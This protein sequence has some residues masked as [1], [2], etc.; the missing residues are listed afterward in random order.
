MIA[1][2]LVNYM[3]P[4]LRPT[5]EIERAI[6]WMEEFKLD[7]LPVVDNG[8]FLG[9]ISQDIIYDQPGMV[10]LVRDVPL[11]GR[12]CI[13]PDGSH[14]FEILKIANKEESKLVAV[15]NHQLEYIGVVALEDVMEA[16]SQISSVRSPGAIIILVMPQLNYSLAEISRLI[17]SNDAKILSVYVENDTKDPNSLRVTI[18]L[19][20]ED[21]S[22]IMA[23]LERFNYIIES[24]FSQQDFVDVNRDR[25]DILMKY[26]QL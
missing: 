14:F 24:V 11:V 6:Q 7:Q 23:T 21:A 4:S 5:D 25:Y 8:L 2:D 22:R 20:T 17:E 26:L 18:K 10:H 19:N 12:E 15:N 16:F 9:L 13:I 3:I 1:K